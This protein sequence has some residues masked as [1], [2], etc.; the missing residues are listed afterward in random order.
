MK[1]RLLP[2]CFLF[3]L[4]AFAGDAAHAGLATDGCAAD[5]GG[6]SLPPG[7][8]ATV[9]A[10]HLGH[11]RHLAIAQDGTVYVNT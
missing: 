7:F 2:G 4:I 5:N 1:L 8:C 3:L 9:F 11:A 10:D 6:L